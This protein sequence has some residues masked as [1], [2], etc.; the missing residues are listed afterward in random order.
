MKNHSTPM[1]RLM[2]VWAALLSCLMFLSVPSHAFEKAFTQAELQEQ[3]NKQTLKFEHPLIQVTITDP[4]I[5][6][7]DDTQ[8][9]QLSGNVDMNLLGSYSGK[10]SLTITGKPVYKTDSTSF[11]LENPDIIALHVAEMNPDQ[12][13]AV[14]LTLNQALKQ[15]LK[16]VPIYT[17]KDKTLQEKMAKSTLESVSI[18]NKSLVLDFSLL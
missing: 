14:R 15:W 1:A 13:D 4:V 3:L 18:R 12:V 16:S 7:F 8:K 5:H 2:P 10:G 9:L 11:Y 17:L 6:L